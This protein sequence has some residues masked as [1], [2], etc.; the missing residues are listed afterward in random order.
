MS[1]APSFLSSNPS[2]SASGILASRAGVTPQASSPISHA[3]SV[4]LQ[5]REIVR[6]HELWQKAKAELRAKAAELAELKTR[7][8]YADLAQQRVQAQMEDTAQLQGEVSRLQERLK[9]ADADLEQA[10]NENDRWHAHSQHLTLQLRES[11]GRLGEATARY[12]QQ[13]LRLKQFEGRLGEIEDEKREILTRSLAD[14]RDHDEAVT[15]RNRKLQAQETRIQIQEEAVAQLRL[16]LEDTQRKLVETEQ[17][18]V[19]AER[20]CTAFENDAETS[21]SHLRDHVQTKRTIEALKFEV[22]HLKR[23]NGRMVRLLSSTDEYKDFLANAVDSRGLT[24]APP[25]KNIARGAAA[26][27]RAV[28]SMS[29]RPASASTGAS[30]KG[31]VGLS[32]GGDSSGASK[33]R[34]VVQVDKD[35]VPHFDKTLLGQEYGAWGDVE[36]FSKV[37]KDGGGVRMR[38]NDPSREPENWLPTDTVRLAFDFKQRHMNHVSM[39]MMN[40]FLQQLNEIFRLR[41]KR[42]VARAKQRWQT[43]VRDLKRQLQQRVPYAEVIQKV[44]EKEI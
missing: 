14:V 15:L 26:R 28:S 40:E 44:R 7:V 18:A 36:V 9:V 42:H 43:Q 23:D 19:R 20:R 2:L 41:E 3:A 6:I 35:S 27:R 5:Q 39:S 22:D 29:R 11:E 38:S 12:R 21:R 4:A 34:V 33:S 30:H 24:F 37:Y 32:G 17:R 13:G 8:G 1:E 25:R 10:R 31:K 16:D